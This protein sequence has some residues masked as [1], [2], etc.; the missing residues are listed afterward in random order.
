MCGPTGGATSGTT[1]GE[2]R[3]VRRGER[4]SE[5]RVVWGLAHD[6]PVDGAPVCADGR[7]AL[8]GGATCAAV[9]GAAQW[10]GSVWRAV[11]QRA[12]CEVRRVRC[13]GVLWTLCMSLYQ[14]LI[15]LICT[16]VS[17]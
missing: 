8:G 17:G 2:V 3:R 10:C 1:S 13:G 6:T 4:H 11:W 15:R 5:R 16:T 14:A 7:D 12:A 9:C